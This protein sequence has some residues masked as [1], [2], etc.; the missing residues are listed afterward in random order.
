MNTPTGPDGGPLAAALALLP[1]TLPGLDRTN[2]DGCGPVAVLHECAAEAARLA[3]LLRLAAAYDPPVG[4]G[5]GAR[6]VLLARLAADA[7][8]LAAVTRAAAGAAPG[9][10]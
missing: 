7:D 2:L 3:A 6:R 10:P 1:E 8:R 4:E 5:E 9:A